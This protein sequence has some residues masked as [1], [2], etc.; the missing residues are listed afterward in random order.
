[1]VTSFVLV[2]PYNAR[3]TQFGDGNC[4]LHASTVSAYALQQ[5]LLRVVVDGS[6]RLSCNAFHLRRSSRFDTAFYG[7]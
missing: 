6:A 5:I 1:M 3:L 2:Y 4:F 7:I